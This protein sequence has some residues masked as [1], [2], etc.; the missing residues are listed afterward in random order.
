VPTI[1]RLLLERAATPELIGSYGS[2]AVEVIRASMRHGFT[3]ELS[4]DAFGVQ[5]GMLRYTGELTSEAPTAATQSA[6][7]F[8][9]IDA[10]AAYGADVGVFLDAF[11]R[12]LRRRLTVEERTRALHG[13]RRAPSA[14]DP[15]ARDAGQRLHAVLLRAAEAS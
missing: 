15:V 7:M 8:K 13:L 14:A 4:P 2:A 9:A 3:A 6:S 12:A 5:Q 10:L 11:E 1:A